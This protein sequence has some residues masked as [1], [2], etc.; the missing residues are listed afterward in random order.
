MP[1]PNG[2]CPVI[3][4]DRGIFHT[5]PNCGLDASANFIVS[6]NN[7]TLNNFQGD[8]STV[9][10]CLANVGD[11]GCGYE[12]QLQAT[13]VALYESITPQN[14]GF[15]RDDAMLAI[16]L[17]T[18]EDDCSAEPTTNLFVDDA[19]FPG[20]TASFRCAQVGHLCDGKQPPVGTFQA[21]LTSCTTNDNGRLIPVD[22]VVTSIKLLKR[23]P[24]Q[25]IVVSGIFGWSTAPDAQYRYIA[26]PDGIDYGPICTSA[27]GNATAAIRMKKFVESFG[28]AGAFFSICD[29]DFSP[30]LQQIGSRLAGRL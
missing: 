2:G 23:N 15:L 13:R 22:Q 26:T 27:N 1:L 16:V 28:N 17:I 8:L 5:A 30:A 10:S 9:F 11:R 24:A 14:K 25:Q 3:G 12:H 18:D 4:G 21:A 29:G 19:A 20:T 6:A 7:G